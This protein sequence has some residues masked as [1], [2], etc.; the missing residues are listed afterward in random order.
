M[1]GSERELITMDRQ[2]SNAG[3]AAKIKIKR[4]RKTLFQIFVEPG[5]GA[6]EAIGLVLR[7]DKEMAFAG[8][9]N[10]L[11]RHIERSECVPEFIRL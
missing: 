8:I 6:I 2:E 1:T 10:E 5:D 3:R 9:D 4:K 7:F 11:G